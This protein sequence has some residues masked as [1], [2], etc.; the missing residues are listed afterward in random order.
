M[1]HM[2]SAQSG[3]AVLSDQVWHR[4]VAAVFYQI[5][6]QVEGFLRGFQCIL[7]GVSSRETA[8]QIGYHQAMA[9][10]VVSMQDY[11]A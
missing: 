11:R 6:V 8:G 1:A 10:A 5:Q 3:L 4:H 9:D 7:E 2:P